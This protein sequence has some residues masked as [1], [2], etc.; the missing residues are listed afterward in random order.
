MNVELIV[1]ARA[2]LG[3]GPVWDDRGQC[4]YWVDIEAGHLHRYQPQGDPDRVW[5][6]GCKVGAAVLRGEQDM[7]IAT[8]R[9]FELF[10]L[11]AGKT[12]L[13]VEPERDLPNNRFNDGKC[14]PQGR[15]WAGT[16]SMVREPQAGSLYVLE[17]D[18][19]VRCLSASLL[20]H[21]G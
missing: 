15:F 4:L 5:D 7:I 1:D 19:S 3:E 18:R 8:E 13:W 10:D 21:C 14:D 11:P 6:I 9:G 2:A 16:M 12:T 17:H 20:D